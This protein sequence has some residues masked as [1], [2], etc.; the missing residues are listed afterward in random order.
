MGLIDQKKEIFTTIGAYTSMSQ[1]GILPDTTNIFPSINNKKDIVP[2]LLDIMKVILG[3]NALQQLTGK[4]FTDFIDKIEPTLKASV[5]NQTIQSNSGTVIPDE[6]KNNGYNIKVKD[7]DIYGMFKISPASTSGNLIYDMSKPNFNKSAYQAIENAGT[8]TIFGNIIIKYNSS[9]DSFNFKP[10]LAITG[11]NPKIGDFLDGFVNNM[12]IINKKTFIS[13]VMNNMYGTIT[14][15]QKKTVEEI[16]FELEINKLIEQLMNN[17]DSFIILPE[18]RE[19]I[20]LRAQEIATGVVSYSIGSE[21]IHASLSLDELSDLIKSISGSTDPFF[22]GNAINA[23]ITESTKNTPETAENNLETIKDD[24]FQRLVNLITES[25]S[26][27]VTTS[28]QIRVLHGIMSGFQN[29]GVIQISNPK[30]DLM[31]FKVC[32]GCVIKTAMTLINKYIFDLIVT[33]L[34]NLLTPIIKIIVREKLNQYIKTL[35]SLNP[36]KT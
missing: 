12:E 35:Q 14:S 26:L 9:T 15:T 30:D 2:L 25:L 34:N 10:N 11:A 3:T 18:D 8:D 4:L 17:N 29:N 27:S 21:T 32:L 1:S 6:F 36:I 28:P 20:L 13:D 16:A 33:A 31:K 7:I 22:V 23:T 5:I 24:F 19:I